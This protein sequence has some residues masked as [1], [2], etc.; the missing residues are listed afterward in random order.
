MKTGTKVGLGL[1]AAAAV[2]ASLLFGKNGSKNRQK[3][4]GWMSKSKSNVWDK[5]KVVR[6]LDKEDYAK[7]ADDL[8]D[9]YKRVKKVSAPELK[10]LN[11]DLKKAWKVLSEE[12][13]GKAK[14]GNPSEN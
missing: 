9:R 6:K 12:L 1:T 5:V 7:L 10:K 8:M 13:K 2:A 4:K 11:T 3:V 14:V